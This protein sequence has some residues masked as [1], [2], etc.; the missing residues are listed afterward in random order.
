MYGTKARRGRDLSLGVGGERDGSV[1]GGD[2]GSS[3]RSLRYLYFVALW[4]WSAGLE[5]LEVTVVFRG[6]GAFC[7]GAG[8]EL[9]H[10]LTSTSRSRLGRH[11]LCV[12]CLSS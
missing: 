4:A 5:V 8:W 2:Q 6:L 7:G 10:Q 3:D 1:E 9:W 12:R 11:Y